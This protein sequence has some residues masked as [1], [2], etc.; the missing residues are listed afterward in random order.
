MPTANFSA[1]DEFRLPGEPPGDWL[2]GSGA[3]IPPPYAT[4]F[5]DQE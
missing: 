2:V 4:D 1:D 3:R 5:Q